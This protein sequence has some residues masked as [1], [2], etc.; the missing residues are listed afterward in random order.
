MPYGAEHAGDITN[1]I[2]R[3]RCGGVEEGSY[4]G[5][6]SLSANNRKGAFLS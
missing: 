1:E 3:Q 6:R 4:Q 5:M 2:L